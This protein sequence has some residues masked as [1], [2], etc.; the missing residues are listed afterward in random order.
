MI[1]EQL[2]DLIVYTRT[3]NINTPESIESEI[4]LRLHKGERA[5]V[6]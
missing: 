6:E 4:S 3:M 5:V 1:K 2:I